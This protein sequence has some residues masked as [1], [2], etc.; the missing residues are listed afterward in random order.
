VIYVG[1]FSKSLSP[2]LR[3]GFLVAPRTLVPA[4]RAAR[5][6]VD[7]CP[8]PPIQEALT[9]FITDGYLDQHL[10]RTRRRYAERHRLMRRS[11]DQFLPAGCPPKRGCTSP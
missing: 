2:A 3:V 10:R 11:L 1:T 9:H 5:Q 6:A 7:W 8:P 4:L